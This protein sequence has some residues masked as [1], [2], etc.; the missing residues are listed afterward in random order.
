M[1]PGYRAPDTPNLLMGQAWTRGRPFYP[2][3]PGVT[4][5]GCDLLAGSNSMS[6]FH[7]SP[8]SLLGHLYSLLFLL[9]WIVTPLGLPPML[10]L[11]SSW[12]YSSSN[13]HPFI[14]KFSEL[15]VEVSPNLF[16][17]N[18]PFVLAFS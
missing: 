3:L 6:F 5:S 4:P 12:P 1:A 14:H 16:L 9:G 2:L 7:L 18:L 13:L 8:Y 15:L 10:R 11:P 17:A